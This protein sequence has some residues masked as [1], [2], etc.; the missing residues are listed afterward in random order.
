MYYELIRND[1]KFH[2]VEELIG[3]DITHWMKKR[4][5]LAG[6]RVNLKD[7]IEFAK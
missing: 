2:K 4:G 3:F 1:E 6:D 7:Q 5:Y